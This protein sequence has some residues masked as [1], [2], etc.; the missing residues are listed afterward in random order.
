MELVDAIKGR[1]SIRK[2]TSEPVA[3]EVIEEILE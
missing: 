1:R 3:R 2:Y